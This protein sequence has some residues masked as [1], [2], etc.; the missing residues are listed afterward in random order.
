MKALQ[1]ERSGRT[2]VRRHLECP[3]RT[4][5]VFGS[6]SRQTG[7]LMMRRL[8]TWLLCA[9]AL[10]AA[11]TIAAAQTTTGTISGRVVD[12]Q[13]LTLPG[14]TV[15]AESPNLQ[16]VRTITTSENG[17]YVFTLLPPGAYKIT[18]E[19]SG[20]QRQERTVTLAPT[21]TLPLD[22]TMGLSAI[23]ESV[24]VVGRAA[25]VLTQTAQVATDF[26]QELLATL[27]TNR[28][29]NAAL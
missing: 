4:R 12:S 8:R 26:K 25:D 9:A 1:A 7:G 2:G 6:A 10:L 14:V 24:N 21:Q 23:T 17:D 29:I 15:S 11:A 13:G 5:I 19:L 16:G 28:D 22:V 18:L 3:H 20:F 27:P